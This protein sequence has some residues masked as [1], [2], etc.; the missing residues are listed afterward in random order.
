MPALSDDE[1][2]AAGFTLAGY[3]VM[4]FTLLQPKVAL[5]GTG[6]FVG[7]PAPAMPEGRYQYRE[8]NWLYADGSKITRA[9]NPT[10]G[11]RLTEV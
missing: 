7:V 11:E 4:M 10:I 6:R 3:V 9:N 5:L 1:I 2:R 8:R